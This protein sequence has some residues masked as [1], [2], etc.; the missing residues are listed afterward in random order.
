[1]K[2]IF[3]KAFNGCVLCSRVLLL[4]FAAAASASETADAGA[5]ARRG[6]FEV[7]YTIAT[8]LDQVTTEAVTEY[9]DVNSDVTWQVYVPEA[10]DPGKPAG[11]MVYISPTDKGWL[12]RRWQPVIDD[13]N[14]IWIAAHDSGNEKIVA[15]RMLY[16]VLGPQIVRSMYHID[17]DRVY[18][19]G[20]S[21]GGKVSGIVAINFANVFRG[22]IYICGA[23]HWL[24][25]PPAHFEHVEKNRYVFLTGS[26]DFNRD[27]TS[28]IFR[29][30]EAAG[31]R[32]IEFIK[33]PRM[34]HSNPPTRYFQMAIDFLD[35]RIGPE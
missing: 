33:V 19:S 22:A 8:L 7:T 21:G 31:L 34:G 32:N 16:A 6:Q 29:K 2:T 10:Y 4:L 26:N 17:P 14:L 13:S 9:M 15:I 12:P 23:E 18:L 35:Q 11:L 24:E 5:D 27:L 25:D 1:M 28:R 30:Y 20:F 3:E